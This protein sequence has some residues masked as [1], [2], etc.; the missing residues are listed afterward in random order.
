MCIDQGHRGQDK[1]AIGVIGILDVQSFLFSDSLEQCKILGLCVLAIWGASP[2]SVAPQVIEHAFKVRKGRF[3][4]R[5]GL[6]W[7]LIEM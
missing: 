3:R 4:L 5:G 6:I 2:A 7:L 1:F